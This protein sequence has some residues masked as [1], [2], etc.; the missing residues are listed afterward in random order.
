MLSACTSATFTNPYQ[1]VPRAATVKSISADTIPET[2]SSSTHQIDSIEKNEITMLSTLAYLS[3]VRS[4][5]QRLA[6]NASKNFSLFSDFIP[7]EIDQMSRKILR[8]PSNSFSQSEIIDFTTWHMHLFQRMDVAFNTHDELVGLDDLIV[9]MK[10]SNE[11][12]RQLS[13]ASDSASSTTTTSVKSAL[14]SGSF[15]KNIRSALT[16]LRHEKWGFGKSN[17][18][19]DEIQK[20]V[21]AEDHRGLQIDEL[22]RLTEILTHLAESE[23]ENRTA[24]K[25]ISLQVD[26]P[27]P[28][29]TVNRILKQVIVAEINKKRIFGLHTLGTSLSRIRAFLESAPEREKE[30]NLVRYLAIKFELLTEHLNQTGNSG[31]KTFIAECGIYEALTELGSLLAD[32]AQGTT[33]LIKTQE[34]VAKLRNG[35]AVFGDIPLRNPATG[36]DIPI[37]IPAP[38]DKLALHAMLLKLKPKM[39]EARQV[40]FSARE[41]NLLDRTIQTLMLGTTSHMTYADCERVIAYLDSLTEE[42]DSILANLD[43]HRPDNSDQIIRIR[44]AKQF[45]AGMK[46]FCEAAESRCPDPLDPQSRVGFLRI[47][48]K[49]HDA[50]K[51][52][53]YPKNKSDTVLINSMLNQTYQCL[54]DGDLS[55]MSPGQ[56]DFISLTLEKLQTL[57]PSHDDLNCKGYKLGFLKE[58]L[59]FLTFVSNAAWASSAREKIIDRLSYYIYG[60]QYD[61]SYAS[62][63]A[64]KGGIS[65][66][67]PFVQVGFSAGRIS[68]DMTDDEGYTGAKETT[69]V[70]GGAEANIG[71]FIGGVKVFA[72]GADITYERGQYKEWDN[73]RDKVADNFQQMLKVNRNDTIIAKYCQRLGKNDSELQGGRPT[74]TQMANRKLATPNKANTAVT[75]NK[76]QQTA[77]DPVPLRVE[78]LEISLENIDKIRTLYD[79]QSEHMSQLFS[80]LIG[81]KV[82]RSDETPAVSESSTSRTNIIPEKLPMPERA[83]L[84]IP[85]ESI[86]ANVTAK[87]GIELPSLFELSMNGAIGG[88]KTAVKVPR[89]SGLCATLNRLNVEATYNDIGKQNRLTTANKIR[90]EITAKSAVFRKQ[91]DRAQLTAASWNAAYT[92]QK[93]EEQWREKEKIQGTAELSPEQ[94]TKMSDFVQVE[95]EKLKNIWTDLPTGNSELTLESHELNPAQ[96]LENTEILFDRLSNAVKYLT[97]DFDRYTK[98]QAQLSYGDPTS[99]ESLAAMNERLGIEDHLDENG[100]RQRKVTRIEANGEYLYRI[101]V[102]TAWTF[103][104]A[105]ELEAGA[106]KESLI[107]IEK[108]KKRLMELE[109][110]MRKCKLE[111]GQKDPNQLASFVESAILE[112]REGSFKTSANVSLLGILGPQLALKGTWRGRSHTNPLRSGAYVDLE[113]RLTPAMLNTIPNAHLIEHIRNHTLEYGEECCNQVCDSL[114]KFM[115]SGIITSDDL[116]FNFKLY[117]PDLFP[118]LGYR[119]WNLRVNY[120][121]G[122]NITVGSPVVLMSGSYNYENT[123]VRSLADYYSNDSMLYFGLRYFHDWATLAISKNGKIGPQSYWKK[124]KNQQ[125]KTL[126]ELLLKIGKVEQKKAAE[127]DESRKLNLTCGVLD[128]LTA[129]ESVFRGMPKVKVEN[130]LEIIDQA[131][132]ALKIATSNFATTESDIDYKAALAAFENLMSAYAP[133]LNT[134]RRKSDLFKPEEFSLKEIE[135]ELEK[136][137]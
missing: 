126:R 7:L 50:M 44:S 61:P 118:G 18:I 59:K 113:L 55:T 135:W 79:R 34:E 80:T 101:Q 134:M 9:K 70:G 132:A 94:T 47:F 71:S 129:L 103:S 57:L 93:L 74:A 27:N 35:F 85:Y 86:S 26:T 53:N 38:A 110:A 122:R 30:L 17:Q 11:T 116:V 23:L 128:E 99:Y 90:A 64:H 98:F 119:F 65:F 133:L 112:T 46:N 124:V 12:S 37:P 14:Q 91:L 72:V 3:Q 107:K 32:S 19:V 40:Q 60:E 22:T 56:W 48:R 20:I 6:K 31:A 76:A 39:E 58:N 54:L 66:H 62:T 13:Q 87:A 92:T 130:N 41:S 108:L 117:K 121:K 123:K 115:T 51:D 45:I 136:L 28:R 137:P 89:H 84:N 125:E 4:A 10:D 127:Q 42:L 73:V 29:L 83:G 102:L 69:A 21:D 105:L 95:L 81:S 109:D 114:A 104:R 75:N 2:V 36:T 15:E 43:S 78:T 111:I 100:V 67:L 5:Y 52:F 63:K 16:L 97:E 1:I 82:M 96:K 25:E 120:S 8:I 88:S 68:G 106:T 131:R 33:E 24:G 49:I 77:K